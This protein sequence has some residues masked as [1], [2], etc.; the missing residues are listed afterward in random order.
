MDQDSYQ[1]EP[2]ETEFKPTEVTPA[3]HWSLRKKLFSFVVI[4]VIIIFGI[5]GYMWVIYEPVGPNIVVD[6]T[7]KQLCE[8]TSG[9]YNPCP[10]CPKGA[11]C[12]I[13]VPCQCPEKSTFYD[14]KGCVYDPYPSSQRLCES[15]GGEYVAVPLCG[16]TARCKAVVPCKCPEDTS[17]GPQGCQSVDIMQIDPAHQT[18]ELDDDCAVTPINCRSC[19]CDVV[20]SE[21]RDMYGEQFNQRCVDRRRDVLC[22]PC[23]ADNIRCVNGQC[24]LSDT[25]EDIII[26]H[27]KQV[28]FKSP[29]PCYDDNNLCDQI[30]TIY[31]SGLLVKFGLEETTEQLTSEQLDQIKGMIKESG[32]MSKTCEIINPVMDAFAEYTLN[33]DGVEK[34][35][36]FPGCADELA[37]VDVLIGKMLTND[38]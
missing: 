13:C 33:I 20:N 25:E 3:K 26:Y 32:V 12:S 18:C 24:V 31:S 9:T 2:T 17:F 4:L 8:S 36:E 14:D 21:F 11:V 10:P 16:P 34:V 6:D 28:N 15:T 22:E 19:G 5:T 23:L 30:T 35:I 27:K 7:Q 29:E 37:P 38:V 1:H